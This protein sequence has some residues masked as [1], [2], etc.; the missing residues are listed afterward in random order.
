MTDFSTERLEPTTRVPEVQP[1]QPHPQPDTPN[2]RRPA[3]RHSDLP[4]AEDTP[5]HQVDRLA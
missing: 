5:P 3:A 2:R 4:A 1:Q